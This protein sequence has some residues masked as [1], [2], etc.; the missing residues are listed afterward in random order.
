MFNL[1]LAAYSAALLLAVY[2]NLHFYFSQEVLKLLGSSF[3]FRESYVPTVSGLLFT[4]LLPLVAGSVIGKIFSPPKGHHA[5]FLYYLN[6]SLFINLIVF[7][8]FIATN[9]FL[10]NYWFSNHVLIYYFIFFPLLLLISSSPYWLHFP[11]R[12]SPLSQPAV[13]SSISVVDLI[14]ACVFGLFLLSL[15]MIPLVMSHYLIGADIYYHATLA[16]TMTHSASFFQNPFFLEDKNYYYSIVYFLISWSARLTHLNVNQVWSITSALSSSIFIFFFY[17]FSKKNLGTT[18]GAIISVLFIL[19]FNQI[20]WYD[21]SLKIYSYTFFIIF[22]YFFQNY[23]LSKKRLLLA[24][25]LPFLALTAASHPEI[26]IH[27][28]VIVIVFSFISNPKTSAILSSWFAPPLTWISGIFS[29]L[30]GG[31]FYIKNFKSYRSLLILLSIY[32]II[33]VKFYFYVL[34][35][36]PISKILIFNEIPLSIFQPV[37]IISFLIFIFLPLGLI[38]LFRNPSPANKLLLSISSL[39]LMVFFYFTYLWKFYHHYFPETAYFALA[40]IASGIVVD[41]LKKVSRNLRLIFFSIILSFF[42]L[43]L[44]PRYFFI[45]NYTESIDSLLSS[46]QSDIDYI[47]KMTPSGSVVMLPSD[48]MLNRYLPYYSGR[49]IFD[50]S[51]FI[52]KEHQWKVISTCSGPFSTQCDQRMSLADNFF[53]SPDRS[54]INRIKQNY[55]VDYIFVSKSDNPKLAD[56]LKSNLKLPLIGETEN[57][58]LFDVHGARI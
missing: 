27:S 26:A 21:P 56:T 37:G 38:R 3:P 14:V 24:T 28:F 53:N 36:F 2:F 19:P 51:S 8:P 58:L 49:Y 47:K 34:D 20:L 5:S 32:L 16:K 54:K 4:Y 6:L 45:I 55:R 43:S 50:G 12:T 25:S 11:R 46:Q 52:S 17:L 30:S 1:V 22:L 39:Y 9:A 41:I 33:L 40:I 10:S 57:Y 23:I 29:R 48:D 31:F 44:I 18:V 13:F 7:L 42:I 35:N 15:N